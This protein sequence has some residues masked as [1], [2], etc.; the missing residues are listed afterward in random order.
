M[1]KPAR[2]RDVAAGG[3]CDPSEGGAMA[4]A[5]RT[6]EGTG[7]QAQLR[8]ALADAHSLPAIG[9]VWRGAEAHQ[10]TDRTHR[11]GQTR[12]VTVVRLVARGTIEEQ[13][14]GL[15]AEKRA[16]VAGILEGTDAV[17]RVTTEELVDLIRQGAAATTVQGEVEMERDQ[18]EVLVPT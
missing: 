16:L 3:A 11:I 1:I 12:P 13:I 8:E 5:A 18:T 17:A 4:A 7:I 10:A 15:H 14:L 2:W 6:M 9:R